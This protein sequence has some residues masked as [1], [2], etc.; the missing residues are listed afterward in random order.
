MS[1]LVKQKSKKMIELNAAYIQAK[2]ED[3]KR[4]E[5]D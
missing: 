5:N 2:V 4:P 1:K 3:F